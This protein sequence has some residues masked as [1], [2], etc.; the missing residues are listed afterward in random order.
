MSKKKHNTYMRGY[1]KK[2]YTLRRKAAIKILGGKC[3]ECCL[4]KDLQFDH[5]D[6]KDKKYTIAKIWT[7]SEIKF[8]EEIR[9]CQLLCRKCHNIKT[10][11]ELGRKL[12]KGFHGTLSTYRYCK[13]DLCR[14]AK[15][16]WMKEYMKTYKRVIS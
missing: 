8:W 5:K 11:K 10:Q 16:D 13:C 9:K 14:K 6:P 7:H 15:S 12:A 3:K 4:R 2:R 1:L